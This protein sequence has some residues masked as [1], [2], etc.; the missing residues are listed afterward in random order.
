M[1]NPKQKTFGRCTFDLR[2]K[3]YINQNKSQTID[4]QEVRMYFKNSILISITVTRFHSYLQE[5]VQSRFCPLLLD[6]SLA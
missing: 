1:I 4:Q 5:H 2:M 6:Q 3:G